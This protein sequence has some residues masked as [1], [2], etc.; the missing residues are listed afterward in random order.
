MR[1]LASTMVALG[2][3]WVAPGA[4]A[5]GKDAA[6]EPPGLDFLEYLGSWQADD[7]EWYEIAEWDKE[8][9]GDQAAGGK[10]GK[11]RQ[12]GKADADKGKSGDSEQHKPAPEAPH[13]EERQ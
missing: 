11:P 5:Q 3:A 2:A 4:P 8:N 12:D 13:T 1:K 7:K 10:P 6:A 9:R